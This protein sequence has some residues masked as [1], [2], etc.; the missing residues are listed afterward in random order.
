MFYGVLDDVMD[1]Y[2]YLAAK[3]HSVSLQAKKGARIEDNDQRGA[4]GVNKTSEIA[5]TVTNSFRY[6]HCLSNN[7]GLQN[8]SRVGFYLI[9]RTFVNHT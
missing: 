3:S 1:S 4:I 2:A 7:F 9:S 6:L 8:R 5:V